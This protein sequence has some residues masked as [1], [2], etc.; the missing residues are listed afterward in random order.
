MLTS[1]HTGDVNE[2]HWQLGHPNGQITRTTA[3][4]FN[5][6]LTENFL[7]CK[8]CALLKAHQKNTNERSNKKAGNSGGHL[9][10]DI[11][12]LANLGVGD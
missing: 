12:F 8:N 11:S 5:I 9:C 4:Y 7:K 6:N 2:Y 10:L 3:K 1:Q